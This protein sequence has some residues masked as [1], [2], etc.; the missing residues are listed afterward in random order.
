MNEIHDFSKWSRRARLGFGAFII[1]GIINVFNPWWPTIAGIDIHA[2]AAIIILLGIGYTYTT[3][4]GIVCNTC[5]VK[6]F[7][8]WSRIT[9]LS[10]WSTPPMSC[11]GCGKVFGKDTFC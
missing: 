7:P 1:N 9:G 6:L 8:I 10:I 2:M 3:A 5:G 11:R 4:T